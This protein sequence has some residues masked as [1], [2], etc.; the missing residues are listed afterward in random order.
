LT[1][2][3]VEDAV[4][5]I[6]EHAFANTLTHRM[7]NSTMDLV[8]NA[9]FLRY[10]RDVE[11]DYDMPAVVARLQDLESDVEFV[12]PCQLEVDAYA[13]NGIP[14]YA[15]SF[16]YTPKGEIVEEDKRYFGLFGENA[17]GIKRRDRQGDSCTYVMGDTGFFSRFWID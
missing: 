1:A 11:F 5:K 17:V 16:D 2:A 10:M 8:A 15:Y 13:T 12:A 7:T 9:T 4:R 3:Q 14:V 6:V